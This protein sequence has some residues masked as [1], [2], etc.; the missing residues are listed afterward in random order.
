MTRVPKWEYALLAVAV[1]GISSSG[2]IAAVA[3]APAL[4]I[5]FWRNAMGTVLI[6]GHAALRPRPRLTWRQVAG[7]ALAG[8]FLAAH[9]ALWIPS[10]DLTSVAASTAL[11]CSA[12]LW[13]ALIARASGRRVPAAAWIGMAVALAGVV[14]ISGV[15]VSGSPRA[16]VGD[17]LA[18]AGGAFMAAYLACGEHVRGT[19]D[20]TTYTLLC[21]GTAAI[22]LLILCL[23]TGSSL[24]GYGAATWVA[25]LAL[26]VGGQL[27]GHTL[28]N[29]ALHWLSGP[30][31]ATVTLLEVPGAALI[32]AVFLRQAPGPLTWVGIVVIL[33]GLWLAVRATG[34]PVTAE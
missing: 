18:L 22:V 23:A 34:K 13:S 4:A 25:L 29:R 28:F 31:V 7:C 9:F 1:I 16:L 15:D 17:L 19:L 8:A 32:A 21:Y 3:A 12:P 33:L 26:T 6:A 30:T 2:P 27:L 11:V 10:L 24:G 5:A 14:V 20:T